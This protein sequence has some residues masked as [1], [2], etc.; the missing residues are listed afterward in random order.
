[1]P[2]RR[3]RI[4]FLSISAACTLAILVVARDVLLPFIF[5]LFVAYLLTPL[6]AAMERRRVLGWAAILLTYA[7]S[8]GS[9]YGF[10]SAITPRMASEVGGLL[11]ELPSMARTLERDWGPRVE[12]LMRRFGARPAEPV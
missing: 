10:F 5:A 7:V 8:L 2:Q 6:V 3:R 9:L 4:L 12:G 11:N 1:M